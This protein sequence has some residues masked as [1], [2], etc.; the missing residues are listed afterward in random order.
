MVDKHLSEVVDFGGVSM[1]R[2]D[3]LDELMRRAIATGHRQPQLLVNAFMGGRSID[4]ND[5]NGRR[6]EANP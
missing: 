6:H 3:M 4:A 1:T 2:G 5:M